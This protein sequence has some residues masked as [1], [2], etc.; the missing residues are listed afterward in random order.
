[1]NIASTFSIV[2]V[3]YNY[4]KY[5]EQAIKSALNQN[6]S[7][8]LFEVIVVD[9]GS[10]DDSLKIIKKFSKVSNLRIISKNNGGQASAYS[11]GI[12]AAK[13]DWVCLLDSDDYYKPEKLQ[14]LDD[15]LQK[16][17]GC[18]FICS[19]VDIHY[20]QLNK[21]DTEFKRKGI[22]TGELSVRQSN[23][24]NYFSNPGGQVY[25]RELILSLCKILT[26]K[27]WIQ[28]ADVPLSWGALFVA[29]R[30]NYLHKS[31]AVYR[32]HG[33]NHFINANP[34]FS[35]KVDV[36]MRLPNLIIFLEQVNKELS[37]NYV[38]SNN[39]TELINKIRHRIEKTK[40]SQSKMIENTSS[41][42]LITIITTCKNRL[43]HLKSSLPKMVSQANSTVVVVNYGCLQGTSEWVRANYPQV[44]LVEVT[45]DSG[46][47]AS[48]ARNLGAQV[49]ESDWL[50]FIDADM[51]LNG[52]MVNWFKRQKRDAALY[53]PAP[54]K[55]NSFG[56]CIIRSDTF[57]RLGGYDEAFRGWGGED[58]DL[59]DRV[60]LE[61]LTILG[62]PSAH[63]H[64]I[65]HGDEIRALGDEADHLKT[66]SSALRVELL[67]RTIKTDIK[68]IT[69]N[70]INLSVRV[71]IM[72][73]IKAC[74]KK[75][76][77]TKLKE[78]AIVKVILNE[79]L[80]EY[81]LINMQRTLLYSLK[82][83]EHKS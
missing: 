16:Q 52:D 63:I 47:N 57:K 46:W 38:G 60:K 32:V 82:N 42:T 11:S 28:G 7:S 15:Y 56:T 50:F 37:Q 55:T 74:V 71:E 64:V 18:L 2:I 53:L 33:N 24:Y 35:S 59:Y 79:G 29:G 45:D 4:D 66:M 61:K 65:E 8:E 77:E 20:E 67:Y 75:Y 9:D 13:N 72:K 21:I 31:L 19:D 36:Q 80:S 30:V 62:Y 78:H 23:G 25:K 44:K 40:E 22:K 14:V 26:N 70:D 81:Q 34:N 69:G 43:D 49:A 48:R 39:R 3:N 10:T 73:R 58:T 51:V 1:L 6:Y 76:E 17:V 83:L 41:P 12:K 27:F 5:I 54:R 68:K